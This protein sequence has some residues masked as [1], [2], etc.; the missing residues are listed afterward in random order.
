MMH[1][2]DGV[3]EVELG[4]GVRRPSFVTVLALVMGHGLQAMAV[5]AALLVLIQVLIATLA[6]V[7]LRGD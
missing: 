5:V 6:A 7:A 4:M 2:G 1:G 3:W